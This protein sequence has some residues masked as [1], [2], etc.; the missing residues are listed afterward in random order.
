MLWRFTDYVN[1]FVKLLK[2]NYDPKSRVDQARQP[3]KTVGPR[4]E[5]E[6]TDSKPPDAT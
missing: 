3:G 4:E 6:N 1:L 5:K 2:E